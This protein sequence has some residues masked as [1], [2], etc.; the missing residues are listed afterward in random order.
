MGSSVIALLTDLGAKDYFVGAMKGA[1][2]S[3]NPDAKI[4]DITHEVSKFDVRRAALILVQAAK[5]FPAGT[6]FITVVDP[7]VGTERKCVLLKT[8]NGLFFIAPDNGVLTLIAEQLGIAELYEI[9]NRELMMPEISSTFHGRDIMA[10]V[11]AH[12]SLGV[13]PSEVGPGLKEIKLLKLPRPMVTEKELRGHIMSVDDFGNLV[14]NI[15]AST[16]SKFARIGELLTVTVG[17]RVLTAEFARTF[18]E[19]GLGE[20][21]CYAGSSGMLE[22]AK[23]MGNLA[24]E[25]KIKIGGELSIKKVIRWSN[26]G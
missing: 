1:I 9:T 4:V 10:P 2:L 7:G 18:G 21:V 24:N 5:A 8:K 17:E 11:A 15:D 22:L 26:A 19:V 6:I 23:N 12:L 25:L 20:Y 13:K 3:V 14:T 16:I